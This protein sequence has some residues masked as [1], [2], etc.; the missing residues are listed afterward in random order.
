MYHIFYIFIASSLLLLL[1]ILYT[2]YQRFLHISDTYEKYSEI[3]TFFTKDD[4]ATFLS[5]DND[6][7]VAKMSATDL[8][9]R[10]AKTKTDYINNITQ[11][12]YEFNNV[13]Q[14]KL[15]RCARKADEFLFKYMYKNMLNCK[16][17][18]KIQWKFALTKKQDKFEY[19]EGLP[20]TR[21]D[22][23][24]LSLYTINDA[25]SSSNNDVNLVSTLIH[26]KVHIFQRYNTI[27]MDNLL[28]EFGYKHISTFDTRLKRSNPDINDKIYT[29]KDGDIMITFY[30]S[31]RPS[32]INDIKSSNHSM[33]HPYEM[34][35]YDI[36]NEYTKSQLI[37]MMV[38]L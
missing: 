24:F 27:F 12:A 19:E 6:M 37:N 22:I 28:T 5:R 20:H 2:V 1:Y 34:M 17:V 25:I 8:Y 14:N 9:A 4:T 16:E 3:I 18:A 26:E 13:Q 36:D 31:E 33:E 35:A 21:E 32:G 15:R 10:R 29:N 11:C 38:K 7:Y 30:N 23:I